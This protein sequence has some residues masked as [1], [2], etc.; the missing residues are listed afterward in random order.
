MKNLKEFY[1]LGLPIDT[2]F[3]KCHFVKVK[4]YPDFLIYQNLLSISK[5]KILSIHKQQGYNI[6]EIKDELSLFA[7]ICL[8]PDFRIMYGELFDF[9][10][11]EKGVFDKIE[12]EEDFYSIRQLIMD[13]NCI[14]EEKEIK[15]P[16]LKAW[17]EKGR[18][19]KAG[20]NPIYFEDIVSS[21]V[22]YTGHTYEQVNEM[23]L[24]QL[25]MTFNRI[26]QLI[27]YDT[28]TLFATVST[29]KINIESWCKHIDFNVEKEEGMSR[30]KFEKLRK[31]IM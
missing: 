15:N 11:K 31:S 7:W 21:I 20:D 22:A 26:A 24:Y 2:P 4:E 25:Y 6:D 30:E 12:T 27:N 10:F 5:D 8:I 3:G 16:E 17:L 28:S 23:T 1:I 9:V 29:E 14:K 13:M 19:L 18:E